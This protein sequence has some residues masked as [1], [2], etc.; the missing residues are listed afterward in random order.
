MAVERTL[1]VEPHGGNW[2]IRDDDLGPP[3]FTLATR[4][5]AEA[6]ARELTATEGGRVEVREEPLWAPGAAVE[7]GD[8][9]GDHVTE[10]GD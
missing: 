8:D 2:V 3:L 10:P 5:E 6:R 7:V 1:R 9:P 4:E